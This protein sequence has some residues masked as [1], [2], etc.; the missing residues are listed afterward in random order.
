MCALTRLFIAVALT[1]GFVGE[2]FSQ[3]VTFISGT[4]NRIASIQDL[5]INGT[6]YDVVTFHYETNYDAVKASLGSA[7][8]FTSSADALDALEAIETAFGGVGLVDEP[9]T[10]VV[11]VPYAEGS[12]TD[13]GTYSAQQGLNDYQPTGDTKQFY[14]ENF[15]EISDETGLSRTDDSAANY[16][17]ATFTVPEPGSFM[18]AGMLASVSVLYYRRRK[19][20][21][22]QNSDLT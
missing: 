17:I 22:H 16:A 6:T 13:S 10:R 5:V 12:G 3:T 11:R 19:A 7:I 8:T 18:L 4:D 15:M 14:L 21:G 20:K 2:S 1:L 9:T